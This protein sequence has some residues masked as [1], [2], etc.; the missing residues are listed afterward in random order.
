MRKSLFVLTSTAILAML[1]PAAA[2]YVF[3]QPGVGPGYMA[4]GYMAPGYMAPGYM[5]PGYTAPG[6]TNRGYRW[7]ENGSSKIPAP[8]TPCKT[9][10]TTKHN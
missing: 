5:A 2:Q 8:T 3:P 1:R 9:G 7:R 4:P 6:F 10:R